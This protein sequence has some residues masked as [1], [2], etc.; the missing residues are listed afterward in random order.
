MLAELVQLGMAKA[1]FEVRVAARS[2]DEAVLGPHGADT[3][4]FLISPNPGEALKPLHKIASG[5][6]LSRVMLAIRTILASADQTP[7]VIFDEVD[8]GIGGSMG[9]VVGRKLLGRLQAT[10]GPLR[11]A[12]AA[13]RLFRG[14]APRGAEADPGATDTETTIA[15]PGRRTIGRGKSPACSADRVGPARPSIMRMNYWRRLRV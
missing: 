6:E 7:T 2:A 12:P 1:A 10:S 8:A 4:E 5:G 14:P 3:V 15:G 9:E 11:H 13:D